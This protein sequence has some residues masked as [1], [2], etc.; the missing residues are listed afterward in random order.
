MR[1]TSER[2]REAV[3]DILGGMVARATVLDLYAGTGAYGVEALSRGA[4]RADFVEGDRSTAAGIQAGLRVL[5][6]GPEVARVHV[7]NLDLGVLPP[8]ARG[9]FRLVF[10]DPPYEGEAGSIWLRAM[11]RGRMLEP[12]GILVY[13]RRRGTAPA[14]SGALELATERRYGDTTVAIYRSGGSDSPRAEGGT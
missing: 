6:L 14:A 9:P 4:A 1:P 10:L 2:V 5:G 13:E 11:A 3:F 8:E 12:G 7:S